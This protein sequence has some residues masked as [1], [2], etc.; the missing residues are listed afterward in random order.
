MAPSYSK[1]NLHINY[2]LPMQL[3]GT[4]VI[5]FAHVFNLLDV[6]VQD[7][8]DNSDIMVTMMMVLMMR[9]VRKFTLE[10]QDTLMPV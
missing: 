9:L 2:D 10:F 3:A 6:Y 7:A 4:N 1:V 8:T 5:V